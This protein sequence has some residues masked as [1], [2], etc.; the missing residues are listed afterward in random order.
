MLYRSYTG[1]QIRYYI[2]RISG[3]TRI[4]EQVP[5]ITEGEEQKDEVLNA[6]DFVDEELR[7]KEWKNMHKLFAYKSFLEAKQDD[8]R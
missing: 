8:K 7:Q 3:K 4:T 2:D 5:G 6:W 1:A